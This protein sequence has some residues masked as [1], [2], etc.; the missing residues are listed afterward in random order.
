MA[1][2]VAPRAEHL[3]APKPG[4]IVACTPNGD[5]LLKVPLGQESTT[6]RL[7]YCERGR[8]CFSSVAPV[9]TLGM[10]LIRFGKCWRR[11]WN[12]APSGR[13]AWGVTLVG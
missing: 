3:V 1:S 13:A 8:R 11:L 6:T 12:L 10:E 4:E 7:G 5:L 9:D 2:A